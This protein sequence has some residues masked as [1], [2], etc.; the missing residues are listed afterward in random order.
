ML[1]AIQMF[2]S[3]GERLVIGENR[4][5]IIGTQFPG[6]WIARGKRPGNRRAARCGWLG[7]LE[8]IR[9]LFP[10]R[11]SLREIPEAIFALIEFAQALLQ[12][13]SRGV[14][15]AKFIRF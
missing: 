5:H 2:L 1:I 8:R 9:H 3:D 7:V 13:T 6:N 15:G 14:D 10:S 12:E 11:L 4:L